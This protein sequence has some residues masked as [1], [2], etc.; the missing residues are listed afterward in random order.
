MRNASPGR[1]PPGRKKPSGALLIQ[2]LAPLRRLKRS[3][4][5]CH[6]CRIH[7]SA[8]R[9]Q[10]LTSAGSHAVD[11]KGVAP[12]AHLVSVDAPPIRNRLSRLGSHGTRQLCC[13]NRPRRSFPADAGPA[14][15]SI[16]PSHDFYAPCDLVVYEI[17]DLASGRTVGATDQLRRWKIRSRQTS[18]KASAR[19]LSTPTSCADSRERLKKLSGPIGDRRR[20]P[21]SA[22]ELTVE[23]KPASRNPCE[24]PYADHLPCSRQQAGMSASGRERT[25]ST[26]AKRSARTGPS[27][28]TDR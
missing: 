1:L 9:A 6:G 15:R 28:Q 26:T 2:A 18:H 12:L 25:W 20:P 7:A 3:E 8:R 16:S 10:H 14:Q 13:E 4:V 11:T 23:D 21:V 22:V 17:A 5:P 24:A 19:L 27:D